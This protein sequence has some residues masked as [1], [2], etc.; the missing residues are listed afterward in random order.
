MGCTGSTSNIPPQ[1]TK[2]LAAVQ[3]SVQG[4]QMPDLGR[5]NNRNMD[6]KTSSKKS[7]NEVDSSGEFI[8]I[9]KDRSELLLNFSR[10]RAPSAL[11]DRAPSAQELDAVRF[12][13]TRR[14]SSYSS[15]CET[16]SPNEFIDIQRDRS[17]VLI[18]FSKNKPPSIQPTA[19][20]L[21][22]A[23]LPIMLTTEDFISTSMNAKAS[24]MNVHTA[25]DAD[26]WHECF[27]APCAMTEI[28]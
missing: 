11:R 23:R 14:Q 4:R 18:Q 20:Q 6:A 28:W 9:Q 24:D 13:M 3:G 1:T 27:W 7:P 19:H 12:A 22:A 16:D 5:D 25:P 21:D 2:S 8:D 17:E 26:A 10:E 15:A